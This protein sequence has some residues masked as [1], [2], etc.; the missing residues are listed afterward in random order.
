MSRLFANAQSARSWCRS[1]VRIAQYRFYIRAEDLIV[2]LL[3]GFGLIAI[4]VVQLWKRK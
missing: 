1:P 4:V 3:V 2:I